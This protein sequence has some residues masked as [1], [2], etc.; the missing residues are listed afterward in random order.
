MELATPVGIAGLSTDQ[1]PERKATG[2]PRNKHVA[3]EGTGEV[4][5]F[6]SVAPDFVAGAVI[7]EASSHGHRNLARLIARRDD[8]ERAARS[9]RALMG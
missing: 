6:Q 3:V 2:R 9:G 7:S 1:A 4:S 8:A 5:G